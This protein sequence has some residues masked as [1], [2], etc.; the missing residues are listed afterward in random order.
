M[1][2]I[3]FYLFTMLCQN[4]NLNKNKRQKEIKP[5]VYSNLKIL[6]NNMIIEMILM[7]AAVSTTI[8]TTNVINSSNGVLHA[9]MTL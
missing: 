1:W 5:I 6:Y 2:K 3:S 9:I 8:T 4:V 7:L